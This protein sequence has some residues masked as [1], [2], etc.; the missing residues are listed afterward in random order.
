MTVAISN[1]WNWTVRSHSLL[2]ETD[3]KLPLCTAVI[4]CACQMYYERTEPPPLP[5]VAAFDSSRLGTRLLAVPR[6]EQVCS[7]ILSYT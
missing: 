7:A 2:A 4:L 6:K 1:D 5:T 3:P